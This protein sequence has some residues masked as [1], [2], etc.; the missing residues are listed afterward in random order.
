MTRLIFEAPIDAVTGA[1]FS[2]RLLCEDR[3]FK[4][5][6]TQLGQPPHGGFGNQPLNPLEHIIGIHPLTTEN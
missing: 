4:L 3:L 1:D 2:D 5:N 6:H